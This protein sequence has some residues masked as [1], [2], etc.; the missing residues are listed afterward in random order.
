MQL[1]RAQLAEM[2]ETG[3]LVLPS[4]FDAD[5]L[6]LIRAASLRMLERRGP[7]VVSEDDDPSI[8]KMIFGVHETDDVLGRVARHPRLV[9]PMEQLLGERVHLFQSRINVKRPFRA[10]GW[11]WH[12][13]FNQW[14]RMDGMRTPRALIAGLFVEDVNPCNGPL[15]VIPG[16]HRRGHI[17]N[18]TSMEIADVVV[19][20]AAN[21]AGI[22][23][24][25]GG[26]G[27]VILFDCLLIHGS[28]A[29]ITPWARTI[30]YLNF[31]PASQNELQPLREWFHCDS[32]V[33]PVVPLADDCLL[34]QRATA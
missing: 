26:P 32:N 29:N 24:L 22:V 21:E 27:T 15:L 3:F 33:R 6:A 9:A 16:S 12:Q 1:T 2:N 34:Q 10:S 25:M 14:H 20:A 18:E 17:V 13:D 8:V 11:A 28:A 30:F 31:T 4:V 7:E 5:E 23:A 19:T